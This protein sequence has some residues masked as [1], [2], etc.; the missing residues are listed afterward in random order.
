MGTRTTHPFVRMNF[1]VGASFQEKLCAGSEEIEGAVHERSA[2][3]LLVGGGRA[4]KGRKN[5][6]QVK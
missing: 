1:S 4:Y 3:T 6:A 5:R 2:V